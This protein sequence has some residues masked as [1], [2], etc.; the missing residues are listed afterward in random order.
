MTETIR[1]AAAHDLLALVPTLAG[2][3]P[4]R[5]LVCLVFHGHR[6]VGVLRY[7]LPRT[8]AERVPLADAALGVFCRIGAADGVVLI[9]YSDRRYRSRAAGAERTLL[10]L[11]ARRARHAGFAVRDVLRVASDGWGSLL[12]PDVPTDGR[13]L[14]LVETSLVTRHPAIRD[15]RPGTI[16][17]GLTVP[18]L[19]ATEI[20]AVRSARRALTTRHT[21]EVGV[22]VSD[23]LLRSVGLMESLLDRPPG[24]DATMEDAERLARLVEL[25]ALP[26]CRDAMMLLVAF[27]PRAGRLVLDDARAVRS[28]ADDADADD[29]DAAD[30]PDDQ[31]DATAVELGRMLL[32]DTME[33]PDP[34]RVALG[35]SVLLR[36]AAA[37][38]GPDRAGPLCMAGWLVWGLGRGSAAASLLEQAVDADPGQVMAQLLARYF[39]TGALPAWMFPPADVAPAD[40]APADV[41]RAREL[42]ESA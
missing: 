3:R 24:T 5:S 18:D 13:P 26:A 42:T 27:G 17:E 15:R 40:A 12:D 28:R 34:E 4:E 7:D 14:E 31:A 39:A 2:F 6:I 9:S 10:R 37:S 19:C 8:A 25:A 1:V 11:L 29:A 22:P 32:G 36:A 30:A 35:V 41:A 16:D 21:D 38:S 33:R 20:E 23:P